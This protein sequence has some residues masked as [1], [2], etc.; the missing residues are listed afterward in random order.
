MQ[1]VS[2]CVFAKHGKGEA[3]RTSP[4][5]RHSRLRSVNTSNLLLTSGYMN[6]AY[7]SVLEDLTISLFD[8]TGIPW[9]QRIVT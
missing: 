1:R 4:N 9:Y 3:Y 8:A 7:Q 5:T 6:T 2:R